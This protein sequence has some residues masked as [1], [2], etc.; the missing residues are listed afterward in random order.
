[1]LLLLFALAAIALTS[2]AALLAGAVV[3]IA[4]GIGLLN[5]LVLIIGLRAH[6]PHSEEHAPAG[7]QPSSFRAPPEPYEEPEEHVPR[8]TVHRR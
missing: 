7:W 1:M 5:V 8:L 2:L 4:T 3:A 6:L